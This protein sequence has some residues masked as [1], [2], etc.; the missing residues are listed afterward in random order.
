[1]LMMDEGS[2]ETQR[3][4]HSYQIVEHTVLLLIWSTEFD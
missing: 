1:M 2:L 4:R 3:T